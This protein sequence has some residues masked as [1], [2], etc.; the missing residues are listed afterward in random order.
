MKQT[1]LGSAVAGL[2][3]MAFGKI[4]HTLLNVGP[5]G[6]TQKPRRRTAT[7][8]PDHGNKIPNH[9][10]KA[11]GLPHYSAQECASRRRQFGLAG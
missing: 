4:L 5:M 8:K 2:L 9:I 6:Y 1:I 11:M 10:K 3:D 7:L